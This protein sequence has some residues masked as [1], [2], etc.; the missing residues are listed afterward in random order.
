[1]AKCPCHD[2]KKQ[3][4][5]ISIGDKGKIL[6]NCLAGCEFRDVLN[7]VGLK[8][9]DVSPKR[10]GFD[11]GNIVATYLY[12]NGTRKLRDGNKNFVWQYLDGDEWKY[13]RGGKPH[14]LYRAGNPASMVYVVEGEKDANNLSALGFFVVSPESGADKKQSGKKWPD[15]YNLELKGLEVRI[16]PDH[17]EVGEAFAQLIASEVATVA[18]SV[19]VLDLASEWAE[20]PLKGDI[21]DLIQAKGKEETRAILT[22]LEA[23]CEE[24]KPGRP[25]PSGESQHPAS[26]RDQVR[27]RLRKK[28]G[29]NE[30]ICSA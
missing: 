21:S 7:K 2:D 28:P 3:S 23:S 17:D 25:C 6:L 30:A 10:S 24:W 13:G 16:L 20:M 14:V 18:E 15:A 27:A 19:K 9:E 5:A 26:N 11:F 1:M 22:R 4:L 29:S 12:S 8:L